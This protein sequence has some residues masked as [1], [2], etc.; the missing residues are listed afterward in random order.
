MA[1]LQRPRDQP[2]LAGGRTDIGR[3]LHHYGHGDAVF[4]R[5][6]QPAHADCQ[7]DSA[8]PPPWRVTRSC[9][10]RPGGGKV[11]RG[12][13]G[14]RSSV[15]TPS[16]GHT[17]GNQRPQEGTRGAASVA[18]P[19]EESRGMSSRPG[20]R[21]ARRGTLARILVLLTVPIGMSLV[22]AAGAYAVDDGSSSCLAYPGKVTSSSASASADDVWV[23]LNSQQ[24]GVGGGDQQRQQTLS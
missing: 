7:G 3:A 24:E 13:T 20:G 2:A 14:G 15:F 10:L 8:G 12:I 22:G 19:A 17:T 6:A 16:T 11:P 1:L 4:V 23:F 9:C 5:R 18:T 21:R